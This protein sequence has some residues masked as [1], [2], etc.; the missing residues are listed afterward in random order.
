MTIFT[1]FRSRH[2]MR[3]KQHLWHATGRSIRSR[4][5][6]PEKILTDLDHCFTLRESCVASLF[7]TGIRSEWLIGIIGIPR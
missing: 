7:L 5:R 2:W 6:K 4:Q 3:E 1:Q